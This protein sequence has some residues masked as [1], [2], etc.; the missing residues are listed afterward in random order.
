MRVEI[1]INKEQKNSEAALHALERVLG[2]E[3]R[4]ALVAVGSE[5]DLL[6]SKSCF[7]SFD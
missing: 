3:F 7:Y 1:M 5:K 2:N 4:V 6:Q